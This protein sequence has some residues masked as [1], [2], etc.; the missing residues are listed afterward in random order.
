M[1]YVFE[2]N[3]P[4]SFKG[5]TVRLFT[6]FVTCEAWTWVNGEYAGARKYMEAYYSP[7]PLDLDVTNLL[8][9]GKNTIAVW[10]GTGTGRAQAADGFL[11][12]LVLYAPK[13]PSKTMEPTP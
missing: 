8:K 12:R 13:D 5:K 2:V 11:G 4:S 10:V 6:P 9:P 7:A 3:V 1:W